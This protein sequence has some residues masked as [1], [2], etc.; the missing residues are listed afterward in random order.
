VYID[1]D[2]IV[3]QCV[4]DLFLRPNMAAAPDVFPPDKFNAGVLVVHPSLGEFR[5]LQGLVG[6]T[7]SYDGG[8]TGFLNAVFSDWYTRGAAHRLP[9]GDNAQRILHWF[10]ASKAPGYWSAV[11]PL[12]IV[13]YSSSPKP[14]QGEGATKKGELEMMWW[15]IFLESKMTGVG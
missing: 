1:A 10:T 14:W 7:P 12:R 5:R 15:R 2:A 8:D 11:L 3:L 4:D 13:H 9:Y 6:E